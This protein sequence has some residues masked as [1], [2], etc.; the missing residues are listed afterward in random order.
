MAGLKIGKF[1]VSPQTGGAGSTVIGHKLTEKHTGRNKYQKL[2]RASISDPS[3]NVSAME[4]IEKID[5]PN[6]DEI[7]ATEANVYELIESRW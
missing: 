7:L 6:V 2:I 4:S 1:E 5:A 3:A